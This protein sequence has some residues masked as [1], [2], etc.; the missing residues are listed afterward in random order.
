[1]SEVTQILNA[2]EEGDSHAAE[3]LLPL[4]YAELRQLA[5]QKSSTTTRRFCPI[6]SC[7]P[8]KPRR[9]PPCPSLSQCRRGRGTKEKRVVISDT[10][11]K[12]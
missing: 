10:A 4:V 6:P 5:S 3:K 1:M 12:E 2:I 8:S 7:F 9:W 11:V